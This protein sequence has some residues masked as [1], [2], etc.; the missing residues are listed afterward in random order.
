MQV[1]VGRCR[2]MQVEVGRCRQKQ[3]EVGR[4]VVRCRQKQ[5][6]KIFTYS[7]QESSAILDLL[8]LDISHPYPMVT[9]L[10]CSLHFTQ[11]LADSREGQQS[12]AVLLKTSAD[13]DSACIHP[14]S[15]L[16]VLTKSFLKL[17]NFDLVRTKRVFTWRILVAPASNFS[18]L[19]QLSGAVNG[20]PST[21]EPL[22]RTCFKMDTLLQ[23]TI[24]PGPN[25]LQLW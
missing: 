7:K 5:V 2:Q 18:F 10:I 3:V 6:M 4:F 1:D 19:C 20:L 14:L 9:T 21:V 23:W 22:Q 24:F 15:L 8:T 13:S 17:D 11:T 25:Y 16:H 12:P